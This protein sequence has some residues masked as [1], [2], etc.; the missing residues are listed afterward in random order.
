MAAHKVCKV[1][2]CLWLLSWQVKCHE[3][4]SLYAHLHVQLEKI[5]SQAI[6]SYSYHRQPSARLPHHLALVR[7]LNIW[8]FI[9][10]LRNTNGRYV[11]GF[12][13]HPD[14]LHRIYFWKLFFYSFFV[15]IFLCICANINAITEI[16]TN[17]Y[18]FLQ[19]IHNGCI[20]LYRYFK[21]LEIVW[22]LF[23]RFATVITEIN[24]GTKSVAKFD[25]ISSLAKNAFRRHN[26]YVIFCQLHTTRVIRVIPLQNFP[27]IS[28]SLK[29]YP[30]V[31]KI[32]HGIIYKIGAPSRKKT[33][34]PSFLCYEKHS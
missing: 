13:V 8:H 23:T 10:L 34:K 1:W 2:L 7:M 20:E 24:L 4:I 19:I 32:I 28:L 21:R 14:E 29:N 16:F 30:T 5:Q 18:L 15:F 26:I 25:I 9:K 11:L 22:N 6:Y 33:T 31:L 3:S 17:V 27:E 12:I